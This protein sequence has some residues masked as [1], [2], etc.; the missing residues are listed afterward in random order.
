MESAPR[1]EP[2]D[3]SSTTRQRGWQGAGPQQDGKI[4]GPLDGE[5]SADLA[6]AAEY[7]LANDGRA[8]HLVVEDDGERFAD[9]LCAHIGKALR[10]NAVEREIDH[11]FP[12]ARILA[13]RGARQ[14]CTVDLDVPADGEAVRAVSALGIG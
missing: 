1:L 12:P 2:I 11:P 3:C 4:V 9:M 6:L 10:S 13:G 8:D 5:V 7:R 14:I